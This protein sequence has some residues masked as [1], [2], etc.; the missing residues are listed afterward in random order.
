MLAAA[1]RAPAE[2]GARQPALAENPAHITGGELR[3]YQ[4]E[5]VAWLLQTYNDGVSAIL[6]D[7]MGLGK[8]LQTIAFLGS[9]QFERGA[10]GP[11]LVVAPMSV[12]SSWMAEFRRWCIALSATFGH[13]QPAPTR[14]P[15]DSPLPPPAGARPSAW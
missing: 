13:P 11:F 6:G 5:G 4:R 8:T 14:P 7:E 1:A 15:S 9:L 2:A 10:A 12:L 3:G